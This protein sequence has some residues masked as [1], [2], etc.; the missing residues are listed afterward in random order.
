MK[1]YYAKIGLLLA[2][3]I[4]ASTTL[5]PDKA[6]LEYMAENA[7]KKAKTPEELTAEKQAMLEAKIASEGLVAQTVSDLADSYVAQGNTD[8]AIEVMERY[9]AK[10]PTD[11]QMLDKLGVIYHVAG[12]DDHYIRILEKE[13]ELMPSVNTSYILQA[14]Y[15]MLYGDTKPEKTIVVLRKLIKLQPENIQNYK[16]LIF[17]LFKAKKGDEVIET[18]KDFKKLYPHEMDYSFTFS[19]VDQLIKQGDVKNAYSEA[20]A[21]IKHS[22]EPALV[23][24]STMFY[25]ANRSDLALKLL[26]GKQEF[27]T[28][29]PL[30]LVMNVKAAIA[31][32]PKLALTIARDWMKAHPT[33]SK[34]LEDFGNLLFSAKH[35]HEVV[36]LYTPY[37]SM[38]MS[39]PKLRDIYREAMLASVKTNPEHIP[40]IAQMY[41]GELNNPDTTPERRKALIY[42][43]E[44]MGADKIALPYAEKYAFQYRKD[45]VFMYEAMLKK[46]KDT[47]ALAAFR[48]K[49]VHTNALTEKE[50][51]YFVSLYLDEGNKPEAERLLLQLA[52]G[53]PAKNQD[54][55]GLLYIWGI[56]PG[57]SQLDWIEGR[58]RDATGQD[59]LDWLQVLSNIR[60]YDR[61]IRVVQAIPAEQ[62]SV[63]LLMPYFEALRLT[64]NTATLK[65]ELTSMMAREHPA[66]MLVFYTKASQDQGFFNLAAEGYEKLMI[67]DPLNIEYM[68]ERGMIAYYTGDIDTAKNYLNAYYARGGKDVLALFYFAELLQQSNTLQAKPLFE[69]TVRLMEEAPSLTLQEHVMKIHS[70]VRLHRFEQAHEEMTALLAKHPD[71]ENLKL[72]YAEFLIDTGDYEKS[73]ATLGQSKAAEPR[74][75]QSELWRINRKHIV[76]VERTAVPN[77]LLLV[78]D[79]RTGNLPREVEQFKKFHPEWIDAVYTGYDTVLMTARPGKEL[80]G[81][82]EGANLIIEAKDGGQAEQ[83]TAETTLGIRRELLHARIEQETHRGSDAIARLEK[84]MAKHPEDVGVISGLAIANRAHGKRLAAMDLAE[85]AHALAPENRWV[86]IMLAD[87][88]KM[89]K[90]Y[91]RLDYNW[92]HLTGNDQFTTAV[93]GLQSVSRN[94]KLGATVENNIYGFKNLRRANGIIGRKSG[95]MQRGQIDGLYEFESGPIAKSSVFLN[96]GGSLGFGEHVTTHDALGQV[97][98]YGEYKRSDW[99]FTERIPDNATRNRI[100]IVQSYSPIA[101]IYS[102]GSL[103]ATS[104]SQDNKDDATQSVSLAGGIHAPVALFDEAWEDIP[105]IVGYGFDAEYVTSADY[106]INSNGERYRLYPLISREVHFVDATWRKSFDPSMVGEV[107]GGFAY[108]RLSGDS[109]PSIGGQITKVWDKGWEMQIRASHGISFTQS[110]SGITNAGGYFVRRF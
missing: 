98:L 73:E 39:N 78:Y 6:D 101:E 105:V 97:M 23:D 20:E 79:Q 91:V 16:N 54:V 66:D 38:V 59:K 57:P 60:A 47:K 36:V 28:K 19:L 86:N 58:A 102:F 72:D 22:P 18:I 55:Q 108:D 99:T 61:I 40:L 64:K 109:G 63:A 95:T 5:L 37:K 103:F 68:K 77:E 89:D 26:E 84:L 53:K 104:Y 2:G 62:R 17:F 81:T 46:R 21:W 3:V 110:G 93:S 48:H 24:F 76:R 31:V 44:D 12:Q 85:K 8:K 45:W 92:S 71:N 70:L 32:D 30:L 10:Y 90:P 87:M 96:P 43:L 33:D 65:T 67:I 82:F 1:A 35:N 49:Y 34:S 27:I 41:E 50:K 56:H 52:A 11:I 14:R 15:S 94:V 74:P 9:H 29:N 100:G 69:E 107:T 7:N 4:V 80:D 51:R 88:R 106:A 75:V 83:Q 42:S 25:N 13:N